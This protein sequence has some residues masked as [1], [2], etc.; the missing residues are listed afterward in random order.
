MFPKEPAIKSYFFGKGYRDLTATIKASWDSNIATAE[1]HWKG[2][3][4]AGDFLPRVFHFGAGLA[5]MVFG[6]A[7]FLAISALHATLLFLIFV[8]I[9]VSFTLV[10]LSERVW[11]WTREFFTVCPQCHGRE[12]IPAYICECGAVHA[13]LLPSSY[14][15]LFRVCFCGRRL[16]TTFFLNRGKLASKCQICG[17]FLSREH[18]ETKKIFV[19][20]IGGPSTGK[21][22]FM[23]CLVSALEGSAALAG[24]E[25]KFLEEAD[26]REYQ[27]RLSSMKRGTMPE[28]TVSTMPAAF[29]MVLE[30]NGKADRLLYLYDPA[31]EAYLDESELIPHHFLSYCSGALFLIDPFS[32]TSVQRLYGVDP[33]CASDLRPSR[34]RPDDLLDRLISV[35]EKYFHLDSAAPIAIPIAIVLTKTDAFGLSDEF[36]T[37]VD[38]SRLVQEKLRDWNMTPLVEVLNSRFSRRRYFVSS[39]VGRGHTSGRPFVPEGILEPFE[40]LMSEARAD[41][42]T[43]VPGDMH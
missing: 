31:G 15:V 43:K 18:T 39:A 16:P 23:I 24:V 35:L 27:I 42:F 22:A 4:Q 33:E 34:L 32:I 29:N 1:P 9:Y 26:K 17:H 10:W 2:A 21:T 14:G 12:E 7:L 36:G 5:V 38:T 19:P 8:A 40:W 13:R 41:L 20:V 30:R 11:L 25:V 37:N 6:T 28:K 3:Q